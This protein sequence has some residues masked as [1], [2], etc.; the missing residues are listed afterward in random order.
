MVKKFKE[1]IKKEEIYIQDKLM[2]KAE[3]LV[4]LRK[5]DFIRDNKRAAM[6]LGIQYK[7]KAIKIYDNLSITSSLTL[8][9]NIPK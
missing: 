3:E 7:K 9:D 2:Q 5:R 1:E 6:R 8:P 4:L